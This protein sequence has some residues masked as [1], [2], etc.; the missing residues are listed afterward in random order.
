[1]A[2]AT[3]RINADQ[4]MNIRAS[5]GLDALAGLW[6][7]VAPFILGFAGEQAA[8]WSTVISGLVVGVLAA[9]RS[10]GEGYQYVWPN[11]VSLLAGIWLA[12]APFVLGF[13]ST[14]A[15]WNSA[16]LGL[17]VIAFSIWGIAST[18]EEM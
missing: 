7:V 6:L 13:V 18:P 12:A 11:W 8:L 16:I 9:S 15:V 1:M 14:V 4:V 5:N 3:Q 10:M 2:I 17:I